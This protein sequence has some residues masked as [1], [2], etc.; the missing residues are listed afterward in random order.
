MTLATLAEPVL[1]QPALTTAD[2][3]PEGR[4]FIAWVGGKSRLAADVIAAMPS[5]HAY[6]EVFGGA[7]WVL[8]RKTESRVEVLN[9][10]NGELINLYRVVKC[11]LEEFVRQFKYSLISREEFARLHRSVPDTLT[12]IQRAARYYY[13]LKAGYGAKATGQTFSVSPTAPSRMNLLRIEEDLSAAH[14]RLARVTLE[15]RHYSELLNRLDRPSTFFYLDPPYF[16]F[17]G[18]YGKG[19]FSREDFQQLVDQLR[20]IEG[21]WMVSLNDTPEVRHL[22]RDFRILPATT[23]WSLGARAG[24]KTDKVREVLI[25]NYDPA[26]APDN[27]KRPRGRN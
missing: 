6:V 24:Q 18:H 20:G 25:V 4:S 14:L 21:K 2:Y 1:S 17:E 16:G 8:F 3:V 26:D 11:H 13:L 22:F 7:G 27:Q 10:I 12:D 23:T 19:L 15:R 5:H 9:D